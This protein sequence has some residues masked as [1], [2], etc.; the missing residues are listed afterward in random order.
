MNR[1]SLRQPAGIYRLRA[2][3]G[4]WWSREDA[5][6]SGDGSRDPG[7]P[8]QL[9]F[10]EQRTEQETAARKEQRRPTEGALKNQP[11]QTTLRE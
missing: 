7:G 4:T 11:L 3:A 5:S 2:D 6:S 10:P 1:V 8:R 9:V